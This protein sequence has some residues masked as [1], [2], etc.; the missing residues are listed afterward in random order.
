MNKVG[1]GGYTSVHS[2]PIHYL[3]CDL[4]LVDKP[5]FVFIS[6]KEFYIFIFLFKVNLY[7]FFFLS[8]CFPILK[9][10]K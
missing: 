3:F 8:S 5:F 9:T 10:Y 7:P 4:I 1:V 6:I 2:S